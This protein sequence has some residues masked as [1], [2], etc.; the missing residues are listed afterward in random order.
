MGVS[1][2][3]DSCGGNVEV[4]DRAQVALSSK[5]FAGVM[6]D[7]CGECAKQITGL[8]MVRKAARQQRKERREQIIAH[9][10]EPGPELMDPEDDEDDPIENPMAPEVD[11]EPTVSSPNTGTVAS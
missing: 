2:Q 10:G 9:G 5:G 1:V 3:C 7:L 8:K 6:I 4:N 11:A